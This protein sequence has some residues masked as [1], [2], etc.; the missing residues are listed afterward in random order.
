[1][2]LGRVAAVGIFT[3]PLSPDM[4]TPSRRSSDRTESDESL[5]GA[6]GVTAAVCNMAHT[7]RITGTGLRAPRER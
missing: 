7:T 2:P 6:G 1:M 4:D 5:G 3:S